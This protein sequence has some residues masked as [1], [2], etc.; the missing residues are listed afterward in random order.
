VI[1]KTRGLGPVRM[2]M[3]AGTNMRVDRC[4]PKSTMHQVHGVP[5]PI[6]S[7]SDHVPNQVKVGNSIAGRAFDTSPTYR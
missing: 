5:N 4:G 7:D 3:R 6:R 1:S 2:Q